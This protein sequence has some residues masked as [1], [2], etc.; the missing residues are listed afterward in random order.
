MTPDPKPSRA[1]DTSDAEE[2]LAFKVAVLS[3]D[4]RCIV[5]DD[6][7]DCDGPLQAHHTIT[8]QQL[9]R[10]GRSDLAWDPR[11][12][13]TVC[14]KAHRR[15]TLAVERIPLD[16][17]PARCVAFANEHGFDHVLR[18]VYATGV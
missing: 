1:R 7:A 5:H 16:R 2:R 12:G 3:T 17:L 8:Q 6:P 4:G 10:A 9:R 11:N 15:H 13:A 14:E 18:K